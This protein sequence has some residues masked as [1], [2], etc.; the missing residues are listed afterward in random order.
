MALRALSLQIVQGCRSRLR[1]AIVAHWL[2]VSASAH[3]CIPINFL[4]H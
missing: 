4:L 1:V 3:E 2:P